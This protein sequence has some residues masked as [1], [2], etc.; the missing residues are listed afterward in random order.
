MTE[1]EQMATPSEIDLEIPRAKR[2]NPFNY[3]NLQFA[4]R[5]KAVRDMERDFPTVPQKWLEWLYDTIENK[6][7]DE[8]ER[9][10]KEGL[11]EKNIKERMGGGVIK[12]AMQV[13]SSEAEMKEYDYTFKKV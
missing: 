1:I 11:W 13:F 10:I 12:D 7:K 5:D 6:P 9:I 2:P 3:D 4:V 8:V